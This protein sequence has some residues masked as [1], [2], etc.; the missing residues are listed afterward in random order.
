MAG[1]RPLEQPGIAPDLS[2]VEREPNTGVLL[3]S[4]LGFAIRPNGAVQLIF[5][6]T[7]GDCFALWQLS[8]GGLLSLATQ[9][10]AAATEAKAVEG[11]TTRLKPTGRRLN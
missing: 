2:R 8:P 7:A 10:T 3:V 6:D 1:D 5:R 11:R 9:L 4:S